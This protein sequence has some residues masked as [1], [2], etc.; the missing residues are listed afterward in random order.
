MPLSAVKPDDYDTLLATKAAG[1]CALMAPF[2]VPEPTIIPSP[3]T[4]YRM[5][6]EFRLW[7]EED[8]LYYAMFHRDAPKTPVRITEFPVA[9]VAIQ[10]V[11]PALL[12]ELRHNKVL[13]HKLFQVEF[14]STLAGETLVT[15][16]YHRKLDEAWQSEAI[17]LS[18]RLAVKLVGR[19][20]KQKLV[21]GED[22]VTEELPVAGITYSYRQ[23]EQSFTQPNAAVNIRMI[24]WALEVADALSGD[25]LELYCGNGNFTL[26][27]A[28]QFNHVIATELSK[29]STRAARHNLSANSISNV[30]IIRL[31]AEE[32][33]QAIAGEREFRRLREL[34]QPLADY[35][36][37]TVFVDPPRAGLDQSTLA[38]VKEF[39][40]II[41]ISCNPVTL[42]DNL[43][44][45]TTSHR[46]TRF[47]LFDQFPYTHHME[48]GVLLERRQGHETTD[49]GLEK[50]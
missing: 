50:D 10:A 21:L 42:A 8:D 5:R 44:T 32:V 25:L 35:Q 2:A 12:R 46:V 22:Y 13:R 24:E 49:H 18:K 23:Y 16:I 33:V 36:L 7:H 4:G 34:P 20:R 30:E 47:A 29:V 48:C 27:L 6:A 15:L 19:S 41:Y 45:L 17:A 14:L 28:R 3:P 11:M 9:C 38:M 37:E 43:H 31:A 40:A 1:V 26:P 39:P